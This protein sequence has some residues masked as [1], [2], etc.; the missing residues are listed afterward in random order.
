VA[1]YLLALFEWSTKPGRQSWSRTL[2]I[3]NRETKLTDE[4]V[5]CRPG[6]MVQEDVK[7]L[8]RFVEVLV[9]ELLNKPPETVRKPV[10][11][12]KFISR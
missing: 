8:S 2:E 3:S 11:R 9:A 7:T 4:F 10:H 12:S 6:R 1:N 5:T